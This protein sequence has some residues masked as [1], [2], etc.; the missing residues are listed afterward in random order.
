[1]SS[2][3]ECLNMRGYAASLTVYIVTPLVLSLVVFLFALQRALCAHNCTRT[4]LFSTAV[5]PVLKLMFVAYPLVTNIAFDAFACYTID[6]SE[7]LKADVSIECHTSNHG[8]V[9]ALAWIAILLYPIG[10]LGTFAALLFAARHAI[11]TER[12]T[13]L[14]QTIAFLHRDFD[15]D[16]FWWELIEVCL[17]TVEAPRAPHSPHIPL[18]NRPCSSPS[19]P[20]KCAKMLR[21]FVLVGLM[22]LA[23]GSAIQLVL[24]TALSTAFLHFQVLASPYTVLADDFLASV[25]SFALVS[26]FLCSIAFK[27]YELVALE[28][29]RS[30]MSI[31]QKEYYIVNQTLLS[32]AMLA[33][34][35]GALA[36]ASVLFLIQFAI[37]GRRLRRE[38]LAA[39]GRR[40]LL[41]KN[42]EEV[43]APKLAEGLQFHV[44]LSH[45]WG[46]GS[47]LSSPCMPR[48]V[49]KS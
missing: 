28:S 20:R 44:F 48:R 24:G 23:Q 21:R 26:V 38:A 7:W 22:V 34:V 29:I 19:A 14:S 11:F 15:K 25:A 12:P 49:S 27:D 47:L 42:H 13:V 8:E 37:E 35:V 31:E 3:L 16:F 10:L 30:K 45:V 46:T 6:N 33:S 40:L 32:G 41:K 5:P 36:F 43:E 9:K 39:K 1:M 18:S 17:N 2:I 4:T